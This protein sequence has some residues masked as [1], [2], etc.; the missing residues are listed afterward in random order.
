MFPKGERLNMENSIGLIQELLQK[1]ADLSARLSLLAYSGTPEIKVRGD[2]KQYLYLRK[3]ELGKMTSTYIG[4]YSIE[5]FNSV[6]LICKEHRQLTKE[7]RKIEK[8]LTALGYK[9]S[10]INPRVIL[11]IEFGRVN[12]KQNIYN[13][14]ILE[15]V[16]TTIVQ[17]E[18]IIENGKVNGMKAEDIQK[19]LNLKHAWDF[20][21]DKDVLTSPSNYY[22]ACYIAKLVNEGF[23]VD[24]GRIRGVPV[25]IG[26]STYVP[27]IPVEYITK[28]DIDQ[29][30]NRNDKPIDVSI[31]LMLYVMK[32]QVFNDGNKRTAVILANHYL[33]SKGEGLI[34]IPEKLVSVFKKYLIEYYENKSKDI[35]AF[36]KDKC[37]NKLK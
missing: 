2:N 21:L 28:E 5:L 14:A 11:N 1:K 8:D 4:Q 29:I 34:V 6:S 19:I 13:Q 35:V 36:L 24:G 22:L 23:Y 33:I 20:I 10:D 32:A 27:P 26:K 9:E 18:A 12:L 37:W 16:G 31:N 17:T 25:T 30:L 7:L 3:R 15:G